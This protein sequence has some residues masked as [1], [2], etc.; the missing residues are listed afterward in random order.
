VA[1]AAIRQ[2]DSTRIGAGN[3][4]IALENQVHSESSQPPL[5]FDTAVLPDAVSAVSTGSAVVC[6]QC[7]QPVLTEYYDVNTIAVC[8]ACR[9]HLEQQLTSPSGVSVMLRSALFGFGAAIAGA[10]LYYAVVAITDFEIGLVAIAIGYM[11]GY[12]IRR[13]TGGR[14]GR[15]LQ[16]LALVLTYWSVGLAYTSLAMRAQPDSEKAD[17]LSRTSSSGASSNQSAATDQP[18]TSSR[19]FVVAFAYLLAFTFAVPVLVVFGSLPG[20][21]ISAAIIGFGMQ[22]AWKMTGVPHVV[23]TGPFQIATPAPPIG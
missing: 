23:I 16:V 19:G 9:G 10:I 12:A 6:G 11:V 18:D 1:E 14:G 4:V 2:T 15:R 20:S 17:T 7:Q 21:V 8:D 3:H 22:Q 13:A 5:Q